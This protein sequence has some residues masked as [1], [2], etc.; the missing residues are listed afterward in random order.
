MIYFINDIYYKSHNSDNIF[1]LENLIV[2]EYDLNK[3]SLK[4][5]NRGL[6]NVNGIYGLIWK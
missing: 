1:N 4:H 6:N 3:I 5:V 2:K